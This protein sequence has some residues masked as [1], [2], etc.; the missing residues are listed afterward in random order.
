MRARVLTALLAAAATLAACAPLPEPPPS[1]EQQTASSL[2]QAQN[3]AQEPA[4]PPLPAGSVIE[5]A[6]NVPPSAPETEEVVGSLRPDDAPPEERVPQIV[7]RGRLIVGID[8]SQNLLS[9]RNPVTSQ[10]EGFEVDLAREI[11]RDIFGN[12]NA[13]DFRF[14][15]AGERENALLNDTVDVVISTMSITQDRQE[16]LEFSTPYMNADVRLLTVQGSGVRTYEDLTGETVCIAEGS[17]SLEHARL[18]AP[19]SQL[20]LTRRW[21]DCLMALQQNQA[22]AIISDNTVLSGMAS[23]DPFTHL[24]GAAVGQ[25]HY[26]VAIAKEAEERNTEGLVRQVNS[27]MERIRRDGTWWTMFDRWFGPYLTSLGPP[28]LQYREESTDE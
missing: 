22:N 19:E 5:D 15:E 4:G 12:S 28:D 26:G 9:F 21:S 24:T 11:A 14:I 8:Q 3:Q 17:T 25:E 23:Q 20:L 27:T 18:H 10:L 13:V 2:Q 7:D 16:I 6:G 1:S